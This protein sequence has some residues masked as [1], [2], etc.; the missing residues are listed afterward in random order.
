MLTRGVGEGSKDGRGAWESA[1]SSDDLT[2]SSKG[3]WLLSVQTNQCLLTG[4]FAMLG[5]S[6]LAVADSEVG[7]LAL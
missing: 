5:R 4:L 3:H 1:Q 2:W 6:K 7:P